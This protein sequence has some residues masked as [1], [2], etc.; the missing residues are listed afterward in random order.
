MG[1]DDATVLSLHILGYTWH[2]ALPYMEKIRVLCLC[3][4]FYV[5]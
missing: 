3:I 4:V 5:S 1:V 2:A